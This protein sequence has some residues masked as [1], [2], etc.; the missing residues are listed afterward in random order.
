M[1]V[2]PVFFIAARSRSALVLKHVH[3]QAVST[4]RIRPVG[5]FLS[6]SGDFLLIAG[7][8]QDENGNFGLQRTLPVKIPE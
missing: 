4:R 7:N 8:N 5:E 3:P 2:S 6:A 1:V